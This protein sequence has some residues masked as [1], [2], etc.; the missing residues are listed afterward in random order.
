W[1][2]VPSPNPNTYNILGG[3]AAVA[4]NDV[5]AVG[6]SN[7]NGTS[8]YR[9]M[10]L[11]WDGSSWSIVP[12]PSPGTI[13]NELQAVA[14]AAAN[15]VWAVG[16]YDGLILIEHWNGASWNIVPSPGYSRLYGVAA[17]ASNDIWAV[18]YR[19]GG[20]LIEHYSDPCGGATGTPTGT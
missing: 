17:V 10:I 6:Y 7:T 20:T 18:G 3:V 8:P 1:S 12:S 13:D 11:H 19:P 9:T 15:D 16:Y 14:A 2:I 4:A 5:W